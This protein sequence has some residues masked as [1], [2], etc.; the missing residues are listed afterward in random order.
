MR[1]EQQIIS[2]NCSLVLIIIRNNLPNNDCSYCCQTDV[3]I[4][5]S[6][7]EPENHHQNNDENQKIIA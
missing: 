1:D 2:T 3:D 6:K 4:A 5:P 7:N